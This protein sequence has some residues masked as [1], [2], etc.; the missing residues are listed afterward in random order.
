[1]ARQHEAAGWAPRSCIRIRSQENK[2]KRTKIALALP[3]YD[4]QRLSGIRRGWCPPLTTPGGRRVARSDAGDAHRLS[5]SEALSISENRSS[6]GE[7]TVRKRFWHLSNSLFARTHHAF[8][9]WGLDARSATPGAIKIR[10]KYT[11]ISSAEAIFAVTALICRDQRHTVP[12]HRHDRRKSSSSTAVTR[13]GR[14]GTSTVLIDPHDTHLADFRGEKLSGRVRLERFL[15][16]G[17]AESLPRDLRQRE[18]D[19]SIRGTCSTTRSGKLAT[20]GALR[21]EPP[22]RSLLLVVLVIPVEVVFIFLI[23]IVAVLG[24]SRSAVGLKDLVVPQLAIGAV[25]GEQL[26]MRA[27]FDRPAP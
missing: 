23:V 14:T 4:R 21:L 15:Q 9:I 25:L 17:F 5:L 1:L 11:F 2:L 18:R 6:Q 16:T 22:P 10:I 8:R 7:T 3:S 12:R 26:G 20:A 24:L 27:A 13:L 19:H